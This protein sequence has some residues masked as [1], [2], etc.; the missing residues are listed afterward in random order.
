M[1]PP[2][3]ESPPP[4]YKP[5]QPSLKDGQQEMDTGAP[6]N[7]TVGLGTRPSCDSH[8]DCPARDYCD[9]K[10]ECWPCYEPGTAGCCDVSD[11]T[12]WKAG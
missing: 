7:D 1:P 2:Y 6:L 3:K 11:R 12:P 4:P 5:N 10:H 8:K 9:V